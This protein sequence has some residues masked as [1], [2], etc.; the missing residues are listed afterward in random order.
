MRRRVSPAPHGFD[1][2]S[3]VYFCWGFV[4]YLPPAPRTHWEHNRR[5]ADGR[6]L[7]GSPRV[8]LITTQGRPP[9]LT[10]G[11]NMEYHY[12]S[13]LRVVAKQPAGLLL[14]RKR[15]LAARETPPATQRAA[16]GNPPKVMALSPV[17]LAGAGMYLLC[18]IFG[19]QGSAKGVFCP[20]LYSRWERSF[21]VAFHKFFCTGFKSLDFVVIN[22][23]CYVKSSANL[24]C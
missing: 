2:N 10:C 18:C 15:S 4:S 20:S 16:A 7:T 13:V 19:C 14:R 9:R 12:P 6:P 22:I 23:W 21:L 11:A 5:A 1:I 8:L 17:S 24:L 3:R